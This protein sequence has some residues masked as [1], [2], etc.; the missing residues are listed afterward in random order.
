[1]RSVFK[2][3]LASVLRTMTLDG[4]GMAWLPRTLI[5]DDLAAGRLVEAGPSDWF[6]DLEI[7]L[8][9]DRSALG[10]AAEEFWATVRANEESHPDGNG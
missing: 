2:A 9:R 1:V 3:H 7:R 4:R 8:Y 6:I 10:K 5:A